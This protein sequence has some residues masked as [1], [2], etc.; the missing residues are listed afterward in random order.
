[1]R[2]RAVVDAAQQVRQLRGE[3]DGPA[4][5]SRSRNPCNQARNARYVN[6]R[7]SMPSALSISASQA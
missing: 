1:M 2:L 3:R 7:S 5:V 4:T 6:R